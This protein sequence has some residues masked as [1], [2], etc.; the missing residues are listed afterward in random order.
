MNSNLIGIP[1]P[2]IL[3]LDLFLNGHWSCADAEIAGWYV[4]EH[5]E[6]RRKVDALLD[7]ELERALEVLKKLNQTQKSA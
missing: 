4:T 6:T 1:D 2:K 3:A 7:E 5:Q